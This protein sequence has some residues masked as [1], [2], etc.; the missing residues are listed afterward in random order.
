DG[1]VLGNQTRERSLKAGDDLVD[2][3]RS[4]QQ[5]LLPAVGQQLPSERRGALAR[6]PNL[7]QV[8]AIAVV[9]AAFLEQQLRVAEN[10]GAQVVEVVRDAARE[11]FDARGLL[12]LKST[13]VTGS[14]RS[15]RRS[16]PPTGRE[17]R[18]HSGRRDM[19]GGASPVR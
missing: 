4:G 9:P 7:L 10:R 13:D 5:H 19:A 12:R 14:H 17:R 16:S 18:R 15:T 11:A 2:V 3:D 8:A 6:F 1:D